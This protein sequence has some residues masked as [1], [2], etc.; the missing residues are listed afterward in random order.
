MADI[1][2]VD[3]AGVR[4]GAITDKRCVGQAQIDGKAEPLVNDGLDHPPAGV[5]L[6][7]ARAGHSSLST[8]SP[9]RKRIWLR[10]MPGRTRTEKERGQISA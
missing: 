1:V 9:R 10:R 8:A 3:D 7:A 5:S 4:F 6:H 2:Q